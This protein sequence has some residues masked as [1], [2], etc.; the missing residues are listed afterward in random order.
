MD[1]RDR[2]PV[3]NAAQTTLASDRGRDHLA[4]D[5]PQR[6]TAWGKVGRLSY[7]GL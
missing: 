6:G 4:T 3:T 7:M 1:A 5:W 2:G